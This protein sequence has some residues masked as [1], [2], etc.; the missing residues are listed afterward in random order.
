MSNESIN[1]CVRTIV[2]QANELAKREL[3]GRSAPEAEPKIESKVEPNCAASKMEE[4]NK[5]AEPVQPKNDKT[6]TNKSDQHESITII[7]TKPAPNSRPAIKFD[8]NNNLAPQEATGP[9][10]DS[11]ATTPQNESTDEIDKQTPVK[12]KQ[13]NGDDMPA[14]KV[15]Q[16]ELPEI[17]LIIRV[18]FSCS[19]IFLAVGVS[20]RCSVSRSS[21]LLGVFKI[22]TL[23]SGPLPA[24]PLARVWPTPSDLL[25]VICFPVT[26][27]IPLRRHTQK[28]F[29]SP[30][31]V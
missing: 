13:V 8:A 16:E 23:D 21:S 29:W 4:S 26:S 28:I 1:N 20:G 31:A 11:T 12:N 9:K 22:R 5:S 6:S 27:R 15:K 25:S 14:E 18:S 17:E 19:P 30:F 2:N 3:N 7:Q 24:R 10:A